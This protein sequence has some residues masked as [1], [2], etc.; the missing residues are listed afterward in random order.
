MNVRTATVAT[1]TVAALLVV[2]LAIRAAGEPRAEAGTAL[3]P[4]AALSADAATGLVEAEQATSPIAFLPPSSDVLVLGDSLALST[5][6]WLADLMS[7]RYVSW[8]AVVGRSTRGARLALEALAASKEL[9]PVIVVSSGTN[10]LSAQSLRT[11]A[12]RILAIAGPKRCV[13][14]ADIVRPDSFGDGTEA[15]NHALAKAIADH[16]NVIPIP[17]AATIALHP[18]W[19]S[20]DGIH[21][22]QTGNQARAQAFADAVFSCSPFDPSA[23]VETQEYLP[24]S[25]FLSPGG[26]SV[27]GVG[28]SATPTP[29]STPSGVGSES[30]TSPPGSGS[31]PPASSSGSPAPTPEPTAEPTQPPTPSPTVQAPPSEGAPA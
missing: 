23:P 15:A 20:S 6:A 31:P 17:W 21:P 12:E 4:P 24:P 25:A 28:P 27:P 30:P 8:D 22:N 3:P 9:P 2:G 18:E 26:R 1:A 19:L 5:Y 10:D 13:V 11:E 29:R 7:D 16:Q 14:W